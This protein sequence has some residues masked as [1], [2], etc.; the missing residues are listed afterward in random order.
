MLIVFN[1]TNIIT[2]YSIFISLKHILRITI[3]Q[4][5]TMADIFNE[6]FKHFK[7]DEIDI[8][9]WNF[10]LYSRV[11]VGIFMLVSAASVATT[12]SGGAIE[13]RTADFKSYSELFCWTHG[14]YHLPYEL[15]EKQI[16]R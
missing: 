6:L 14:S 4:V 11:T 10:K 7:L 15:L 8:D 3:K 9:N 13:C 1:F 12:Y 2:E 16:N 5:S